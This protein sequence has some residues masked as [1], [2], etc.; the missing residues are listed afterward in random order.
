[1][2]LEFLFR[3]L[4]LSLRGVVDLG[5]PIANVLL[6][7]NQRERLLAGL[8]PRGLLELVLNL[9]L[10][11]RQDLASLD[12]GSRHALDFSSHWGIGVEL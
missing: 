8:K 1:M 6:L 9:A 3:P 7:A 5:Q 11:V 2:G 12:V 4:R 10:G